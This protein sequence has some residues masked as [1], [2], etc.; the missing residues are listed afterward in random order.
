LREDLAATNQTWKIAY[1][2]APPYTKGS[3]NSDD[4]FISG[5]MAPM[6]QN[7]V[8]ILEEYDVDLVLCG[9]SHNY[10]RSKLIQGHYGQ[11]SSFNPGQHLVD[12]GSG[13][14]SEGKPYVK[15]AEG[16]KGTVYVVSGCGGKLSTNDGTLNHPV[17]FMSQDTVAGSSVI[18][19]HGDTLRHRFLTS[20]GQ[21]IDDFTIIKQRKTS[22]LTIEQPEYTLRLVPNP[23]RSELTLKSTLQ[24]SQQASIRL[25]SLAGS[26]LHDWQVLQL[27]A[28][29]SNQDVSHLIQS[30]GTGVYFVEVNLGGRNWTQ[31]FLKV[32]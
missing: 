11:S 17:M 2:H 24:R 26:V 15:Q 29:E 1:W 4:P 6:R 3:H 10:E 12:G 30:L 20:K 9:H 27:P 22:V 18:D 5:M 28:G 7:Y 25:V 21:I 14:L 19:I 31:R 13:N 8:P 23:V 16:G 32:D